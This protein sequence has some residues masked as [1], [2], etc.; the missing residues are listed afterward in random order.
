MADNKKIRRH[1]SWKAKV[2]LGLIALLALWYSRLLDGPIALYEDFFASQERRFLI[3]LR[4]DKA[5]NDIAQTVSE[6]FHI[7][8]K[9]KHG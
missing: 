2:I 9:R 1:H 6:K 7:G 5:I 4:A 3:P 8:L